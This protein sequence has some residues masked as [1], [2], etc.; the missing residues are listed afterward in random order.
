MALSFAILHASP[1]AHRSC[2]SS[3]PEADPQILERMRC[4]REDGALLCQA[5]DLC[6]P[7]FICDVVVFKKNC[8]SCVGLK[9]FVPFPEIDLNFGGSMS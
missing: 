9:T 5:V 3:L 2:L 6:F 8:T 1:R 7:E 4:A